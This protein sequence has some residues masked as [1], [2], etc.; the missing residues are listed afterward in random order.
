VSGDNE[1]GASPNGMDVVGDDSPADAEQG[2]IL[3]SR[4]GNPDREPDKPEQSTEREYLPEAD[5]P[6]EE[7]L[8]V[9]PEGTELP[10]GF[11]A[12]AKKLGLDPT[13]SKPKYPYP[14]I[15]LGSGASFDPASLSLDWRLS[16]PPD[17][18]V[19]QDAIKNPKDS[20]DDRE[21]EAMKT[22]IDMGLPPYT[23]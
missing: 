23:D 19:Y 7:F 9:L 2:A 5:S 16:A 1:N 4:T 6:T 20:L 21:R 8:A 13:G 17:S 10:R 11:A 14:A 18:E 22:M 15:V 3:D 12:E